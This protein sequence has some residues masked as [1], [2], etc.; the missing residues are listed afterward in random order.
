MQFPEMLMTVLGND[1]LYLGLWDCFSV[2]DLTQFLLTILD[3]GRMLVISFYLHYCCVYCKISVKPDWLIYLVK[4]MYFSC[5]FL[6]MN[7][8]TA[9]WEMLH[10][11]AK[12]Y[13]SMPILESVITSDKTTIKGRGRRIWFEYNYSNNIITTK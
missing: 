10:I 6:I 7:L 1:I 3:P 12:K 13:I 8:S 2:N 4:Y 11:W 5:Q 9:L